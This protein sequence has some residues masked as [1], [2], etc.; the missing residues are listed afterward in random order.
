MGFNFDNFFERKNTNSR[1]WDN[2]HEIFGKDNIL[3][4][5]VADMDFSAPQEVVEAVKKRAEHGAYGYTI[6]SEEFHNSIIKWMKKRHDFDIKREWT[7]FSPGIVP[8]ISMCV[9]KFT[10]PGDGVIIQPPVYPPFHSVVKNN[11]REIVENSLKL[12]D[13]R[14]EMDFND[15]EEKAK[16][17]KLLILCSPHNPVG[18][19]WTRNELQ[20]L[21]EIC[22][23]NN[24]LI[25]SDEI[26]SDLIFNGNRHTP[27]A[28]ISGEVLNNSITCIS[29]SK[30]FNVAGLYTSIIIIPNEE[31]RNGFNKM[32]ETMGLGGINVFG[33]AAFEA[34][35][36]YGEEWLNNMLKYLEG[37]RDFVL[38]Y[39]RENMPEVKAC[40]TDGTYLM[41]LDFSELKM[42]QEELKD[43]LINRA[44]VGLNDGAT[45]GSQGEGHMRLN[46]GCQR[47][48]LKEGLERI[49]NAL[50]EI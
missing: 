2:I 18:R 50:K 27:V 34:A 36:K 35:Y 48:T 20:R 32:V 7:T 29:P 46:I 10:K 25:V 39:L 49:K 44:G 12:I 43:F 33:A 1:K 37:N 41:W 47:S 19:V 5:W 38:E 22:I 28:A 3:P 4:M 9:L 21:G 42:S 14:Y 30:T 17:A 31:I 23:K 45:F 16:R 24:I 26:H 40:K 15:L 11:G 8:A 13:G 6:K